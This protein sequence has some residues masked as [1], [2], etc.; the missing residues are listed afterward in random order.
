MRLLFAF[1]GVVLLAGCSFGPNLPHDNELPTGDQ[2]GV[3]KVGNP[4]KVAGKWY[5]PKEDPDYDEVGYA[6]WY[7]PDFH[8]KH[9]ANGEMYN[10]NA[11]TAAH[12]TLPLPSYVKVT[13]LSNGR[14]LVLRVN[15]R[16]PFVKNR[17]LDVSRRGAQLLGF[18]KKG[19]TLVRVQAC[20]EHGNVHFSRR[21]QKPKEL[22]RMPVMQTARAAITPAPVEAVTE[23]TLSSPVPARPAATASAPATDTAVAAATRHYVQVGAYSNRAN[24]ALQVARLKKEGFAAELQASTTRGMTFWRVRIGPFV[25]RTLAQRSLERVLSDGFYDARIFPE[26]SR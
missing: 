11:L 24:A 4:Y 16:G 2:G 22:D 15:D 21:H 8:G 6:S 14:T 10:M 26:T 20:D 5:Y 7:G 12:K 18:D 3:Q 1:M 17:I 19:V 9:T 13:N 23:E 25:E